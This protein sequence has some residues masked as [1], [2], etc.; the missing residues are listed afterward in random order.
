MFNFLQI[1]TKMK[2][3]LRNVLCV[4]SIMLASSMLN[5]ASA[6]INDPSPPPS[7]GPN[8]GHDMGGNQGQGAPLDE[9]PGVSMVLA[10]LYG[11]FV[12]YKMNKKKNDFQACL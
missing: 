2:K 7:G 4:C 6:Q 11:G 9:G 3:T 12:L 10:A 5:V 1:Q 8:G